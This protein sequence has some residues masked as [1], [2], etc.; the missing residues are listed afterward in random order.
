MLRMLA[1][2]LFSMPFMPSENSGL[3]PLNRF[4]RHYEPL[5][6]DPIRLPSTL[7]RRRRSIEP[8]RSIVYL[9]FY[10]HN[11]YFHL[12]L[13]RDHSVTSNN[14]VLET[15]TLGRI[16]SNLDHIYSGYIVGDPGSRVFG[17]VSDGVFYGRITTS[18]EAYYLE[19]SKSY[20]TGNPGFHS[21]IYSSKDVTYAD[22]L[23]GFTEKWLD[24]IR[25]QHARRSQNVR[26]KRWLRSSSRDSEG[27]NL[28]G[29][30]TTPKRRDVIQINDTN[31]CSNALWGSNPFC[32]KGLDASFMLHEFSKQDH[33]GYCLAYL[34]TYRDFPAGTLGLAYMAEPYV[35]DTGGI[36]EK[37]QYGT[38]VDYANKY[39][40]RLSLN[41]GVVTFT[42]QNA[43]LPHHIVQITF[44]HELG[45]SFGAAH[46]PVTCTP[47]PEAGNYL[48]FASAQIGDKPNNRKFSRCSIA[49]IA[50]VLH[51]LLAGETDRPNCLQ[52][53]SGPFCGNKVVDT[54]EECDCGYGIRDCKDKCCY[55]RE[56]GISNA[57][58]CT[59]KAS[60]SCS[61]SNSACCTTECA[62]RSS[63]YI[64]RANDDCTHDAMCDGESYTC[65]SSKPKTNGT[66]CNHG[67]QIC[68]SGECRLSVCQKYGLEQCYL[69]GAHYNP[70]DMCLIACR[71]P[72]QNTDCKEACKF[73]AMKELCGKTMEPGAACDNLLGYCDVFGKCRPI[74]AVGPLARLRLLIFGSHI[75]QNWLIKY[76]YLT[77]LGAVSVATLMGIFIRVCSIHTSSS[78]PNLAPR[79]KLSQS[80]RHPLDVIKETMLS[81]RDIRMS[82]SSYVHV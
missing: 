66:L 9:T 73:E 62:A 39:S 48:M 30:G 17:F 57:K 20:I 44:S 4:V 11:R 76:W 22:D 63:G 27:S 7:G 52:A 10:S 1:V 34:W 35:D 47:G 82:S 50:S 59:L 33:D 2:F 19:P 61:P 28:S 80:I 26:H 56:H 65:P 75:L 32:S 40:G 67:T 3:K 8:S 55:P 54:G 69:T 15:S 21:V 18:N 78:N 81:F 38:T 14:F 6:Y 24:N 31:D 12:N 72:G 51:A 45:H 53:P 16:D 41:T 70:D 79:R 29:R 58:G 43:R 74:D 77:L 46:D 68:R 23:C 60:A 5:S 25:E 37:F 49:S 64:C 36:C 42:N 71:K 13:Q